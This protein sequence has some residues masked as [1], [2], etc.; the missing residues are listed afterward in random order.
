[1]FKF[2][3]AADIHLDS[4]LRKLDVYEGAPVDEVRRAARRA[5]ENLVDL[6]LAEAVAFV[7]LAGDLYDGDWKDYNTGLYF[8]SQMS[9]LREADIPV[10]MIAGNHDAASRITKALRLP[11]GIRML[12]SKGPETLRMKQLGVAIHG[13]S[14]PSPV[15]D[16]DLSAGY[17]PPVPGCFNIGMLHTCATGRE[18]HEPY[19][20]CTVEGLRQKG[21]DY[22]ALGHVHKRE[23]L[24]QDP[25]ILFPGNVQ[26]RHIRETGPKGCMLVE[27]GGD[28]RPQA[29]FR[30]L[31]VVRWF[32]VETDASTAGSAY[33]VVDLVIERL[34]QVAADNQGM[35]LVVRLRITGDSRAHDAIASD[36]EKWLNEFRSAAVD[37]GGG[38]IW[39]EKLK[40]LTRPPVDR[41]RLESAGGPVAELIRYMDDIRTN[42]D[43]LG[44]LGD[45]LEDFRKKLPREIVEGEDRIAP[46]EPEWLADM[47]TEVRPMLMHRLLNRGDPE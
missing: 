47:M 40:L 9:R 29:G 24:L 46:D 41:K 8:V 43:L 45:V 20:P 7:L 14:F 37:L 23:V 27:V 44:P 10:F 32:D 31:D 13:Q 4:P 42:P 19:A 30:P 17:A 38:R 12:S 21:Y 34:R 16:R 15:V 26:G 3:H 11:Q 6:A 28:G 36:R 1:M 2:I 33:D 39:I 22:W 5:F 18:G 35:P 25:L